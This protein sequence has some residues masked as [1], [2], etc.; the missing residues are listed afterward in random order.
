M[1]PFLKATNVKV[2]D[3]ILIA[4]YQDTINAN[5]FGHWPEINEK[6]KHLLVEMDGGEWGKSYILIWFD[7]CWH[8]DPR[9]SFL[10]S[11]SQE[12]LFKYYSS[13]L[14]TIFNSSIDKVQSAHERVDYNQFKVSVF[15]LFIFSSR[16]MAFLWLRAEHNHL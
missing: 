4:V 8:L 12:L 14:Q 3:Y 2:D 16:I 15:H 11:S 13:N 6:K 9:I 5:N 10:E 7:C 1:F